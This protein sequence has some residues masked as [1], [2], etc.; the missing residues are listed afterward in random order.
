MKKW[1]EHLAWRLRVSYPSL[2]P[3]II[4]KNTLQSVPRQLKKGG[5]NRPFDAQDRRG[6]VEARQRGAEALP[7]FWGVIRTDGIAWLEM[8]M[9]HRLMEWRLMRVLLTVRGA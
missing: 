1:K 7:R 6:H 2:G 4:N 9:K 5:I 3:R 8:K